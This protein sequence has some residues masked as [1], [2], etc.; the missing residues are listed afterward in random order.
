MSRSCF[1][2]PST[3]ADG[4]FNISFIQVLMVVSGVA[5]FLAPY[6]A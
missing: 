1:A 6:L 4:V 2:F 3:P 5:A